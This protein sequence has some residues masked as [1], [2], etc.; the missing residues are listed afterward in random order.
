MT[1]FFRDAGFESVAR[2]ANTLLSGVVLSGQGSNTITYLL[3]ATAHTNTT[4]KENNNNGSVI[5][6]VPAGNNNFPC[7]I[8]VTGNKHIFTSANDAVSIFYYVE[9][10]IPL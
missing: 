3:G 1:V 10:G 5:A 9:S 6:Y 4:F 7:T 2:V 8:A